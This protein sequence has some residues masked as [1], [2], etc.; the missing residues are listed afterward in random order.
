MLRWKL[1]SANLL[2]FFSCA[3]P[4]AAIAGQTNSAPQNQGSAAQARTVVLDNHSQLSLGDAYNNTCS[5]GGML[6]ITPSFKSNE[7]IPAQCENQPAVLDLRRPDSLTGRLNV[8]N[9]GAVGDGAADDTAAL[10]KAIQYAL[11]HPVGSGAKGSPVVYLPAGT[12]KVSKTLRIPA[13]L[14][15]IGDGPETTS[16]QITNPTANLITVYAGK[17]GDWTCNGSVEGVSLLGNGHSTTGTLLEIGAA[18]GFH[19]RDVKMYNHG[20]RGLQV[21][22]GSERLASNNFYIY[23]VR[24]PII[25]AG[26]INESYFWNTQVISPGSTDEGT[27]GGDKYCYSINCVSGR[28]PGPNSGPGGSPTPIS[29]DTHAAIFVDKAVNFSF[30]GGS[31]KPLKYAAGIQVFNGS[32]STV[33]NFYF[34]GFPWDQAGRLSAAVIAG[35]AAVHTTLSATL[36]GNAAEVAVA[37]TDWMPHFSTDPSDINLKTHNYYPYILL[38]QDY[39]SGSTE[40][41][42]YV[43][44]VKRGQFE[45]VNV[46]G[47][48][49]DGKLYIAARGTSGT[50][51]ASTSWPSGSIVEELPYGFYGALS[52]QDS[53]VAAIQPPKQGYRD[54]CDQTNEHTCADII[55]G[56]IP[57]GLY[58]D[59]TGGKNAT[60]GN[61]PYAG[62]ISLSSVTI[63]SGDFPHKGEIATHR[64]ARVALDGTTSIPLSPQSGE[65]VDKQ[66]LRLDIG[67]ATNGKYVTAPLYATGRTAEPEVTFSAIGGIYAPAFGLFARYESQYGQG[68][69]ANGGWMN[70]LKFA[71]QYCWFDTPSEGQKQSINRICM[72]G[73]PSNNEHPGYEY[74]VW[75]GSK[76]VNAFQ[77]NGK[78]DATAD[79]S[80]SGNLTVAKTLYVKSIEVAGGNSAVMHAATSNHASSAA[81][82]SGTTAAIGGAPLQSGQCTSG[83]ARL[84]GVANSMV[85]SASPVSDP[86]DGFIWQAF[87]SAANIVTV[88]VCAIDKGTPKPV[89]YNVRVQ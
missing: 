58:V 85:A 37:N 39:A 78:S 72:N 89:A 47:F 25:L 43:P 68:G 73:G 22:Y 51:P 70:G 29:P 9:E 21:N 3:V 19:L 45:V 20:G 55:V 13:Q 1:S 76:W 87:V 7:P 54:T 4:F 69:Y 12:Y 75:S 35:G 65:V 77:V 24:W 88:K 60:P 61:R 52:L 49:G 31:I 33:K 59:P 17:C 79:V 28:F 71:N 15:L 56:Y 46:A 34:E 42:R 57:D 27:G 26:D 67:P 30:V 62:A 14:H 53:H 32:V 63:A 80:V 6:V 44:S 83:V 18:D 64:F 84:S 23:A 81:G 8:R 5:N 41:S 50:A 66:N 36:A 38:P 82:I 2:I 10:Q 16:L 74:D 11:D 86:G 40:P 48:G